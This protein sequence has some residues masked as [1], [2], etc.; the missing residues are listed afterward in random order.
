M[1]FIWELE[2]RLFFLL[3]T[4]LFF[5]SCTEGI[6]TSSRSGDVPV[7][8]EMSCAAAQFSPDSRYI[9]WG[10]DKFKGLFVK[11]LNS[12]KIT[13]ISDSD[14]AGWKFSWAPDS[15]GIAFRENIEDDSTQ[16]FRIQKRYLDK[17]MNELVG[18]F[19]HNVWPPIWRDSIYSVDTV[20][21]S[22]ISLATKPSLTLKNRPLPL[23]Y[24]AFTSSNRVSLINIKT[25]RMIMNFN[26]GT[27]SP[28]ISPDGR[29]VLFIEFDTIKVYDTVSSTNQTVGNG[30]A[31]SW[32]GNSKVVY[33][34]TADDGR[35]VTYSEVRLFD[36][37]DNKFKVITVDADKIPLF[38]SISSD[39]SKLIYTDNVSGHLFITNLSGRI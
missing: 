14:V 37:K 32:V 11:D 27:H 38:P 3:V 2:M 28:A 6:S 31:A 26:E 35:D 33:T 25:G 21:I 17:K 12:G 29:Y 18:E 13:Q 1:S 39:G 7:V 22:N 10:G 9:A 16:S 23:V 8:T 24:N 15:S 30:S 19:E 34:V 4:V 36:L 5:T 20:K